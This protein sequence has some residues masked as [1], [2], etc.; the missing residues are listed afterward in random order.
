MTEP[1]ADRP[2]DH[3]PGARSS[4]G[5]RPEPIADDAAYA[6]TRAY[7]PD[8]L[9]PDSSLRAGAPWRPLGAAPRHEDRAPAPV[10]RPTTGTDPR[11]L[12]GTMTRRP[13]PT[14]SF[15]DAANTRPSPSP[16]RR[17]SIAPAVLGP[18]AASR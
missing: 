1:E 2:R 14:G 3:E 11:T 9:D 4:P 16:G 8:L 10:D 7:D 15:M 13:A 18:C 12:I 5:P 6:P 17:A